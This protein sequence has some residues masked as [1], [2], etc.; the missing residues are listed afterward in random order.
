MIFVGLN[1]TLPIALNLALKG[2]EDVIGSASGVF[3][4]G[5]YLIVSLL[6]YI[7]S[8]MHNGTIKSLPLFVLGTCLIMLISYIFVYLRSFDEKVLDD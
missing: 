6:T 4:F 7:I 3:S 8:I 1:T 5:Y 2:Y